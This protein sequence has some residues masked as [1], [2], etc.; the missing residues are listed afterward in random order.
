[1]TR[2]GLSKA[3]RCESCGEGTTDVLLC[4]DGPDGLA[5]LRYRSA[6]W[7]RALECYLAELFVVPA[8]RG[9]GRGQAL[10]LAA[11][12]RARKRGADRMHLGTSEDDHAA[13]ALYE[14]LGFSNREG[15]PDGP[16]S[17]VYEREL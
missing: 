6:I 16:V 5:V 2:D 9:R 12:D 7:T 4:G 13:R 10:M 1:M 17:F 15:R 3:A 14:R 11:M 8:L